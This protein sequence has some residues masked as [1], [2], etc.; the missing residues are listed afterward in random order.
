MRT[1]KDSGILRKGSL[2][3]SLSLLCLLC[4]VSVGERDS[5][6][7]RDVLYFSDVVT[8]LHRFLVAVEVRNGWI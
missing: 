6:S 2:L 4:V 5:S 3:L 1:Q 8:A 7:P